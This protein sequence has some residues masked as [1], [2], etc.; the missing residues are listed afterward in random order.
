MLVCSTEFQLNPIRNV[1]GLIPNMTKFITRL[2]CGTCC[3]KD[4]QELTWTGFI[5]PWCLSPKGGSKRRR[6]YAKSGTRNNHFL[7]DHLK[8]SGPCEICFWHTQK[9]PGSPWAGA[10]QEEDRRWIIRQSAKVFEWNQGRILRIFTF[11]TSIPYPSLSTILWDVFQDPVNRESAVAASP[12]LAA[13]LQYFKLLL[14]VD[15]A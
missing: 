3:V 14:E 6:N 10:A 2:V 8:W 11:T 9:R 4:P 7:C 13:L 5:D 1:I 12:P 15:D